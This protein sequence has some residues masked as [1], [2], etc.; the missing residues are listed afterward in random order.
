MAIGAE[1]RLAAPQ[2]YRL[3]VI[4]DEEFDRLAIARAVKR[5]GLNVQCDEASDLAEARDK[6]DSRSYDCIL[7]D[8]HL[9]DGFGAQFAREIAETGLDDGAEVF[10][11]TSAPEM[12]Q[13][14]VPGRQFWRALLNKSDLSPNRLK[15]LLCGEESPDFA[16]EDE[17]VDR[18]RALLRE[19]ADRDP[20][21]AYR[22]LSESEDEIVRKLAHKRRCS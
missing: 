7:L 14:A 16:V 21:A 11:I 18:C 17:N 22:L 19:I 20:N 3:L 6:L 13:A 8:H 10:M 5:C 1:E 15:D 12:A 2:S 4:D 9:P